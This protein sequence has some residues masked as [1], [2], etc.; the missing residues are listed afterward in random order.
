MKTI[1]LDRPS[2]WVK[3]LVA[4]VVTLPFHLAAAVP[5]VAQEPQPG[6]VIT[7]VA[8][9]EPS[10]GIE[11]SDTAIDFHADQG[12]GVYDADKEIDVSVATNYGSWTVHC[13]ASPLVAQVGEIPPSRL[14]TSNSNTLGSPDS[15]AGPAYENMGSEKLVA[16]GG[17][18]PLAVANTMRFRLLTDWT[19][20]PGQYTGTI[21]FTYIATP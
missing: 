2:A 16:T 13:V 20:R 1:E 6:P 9:I 4:L 7:V 5:S 3:L 12:P 21:A 14:F 15:G 8:A 17:P 10:L 19:D 18:Q 11:L